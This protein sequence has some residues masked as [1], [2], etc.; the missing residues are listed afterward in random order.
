MMEL[1]ED[2]PLYNHPML[3]ALRNQQSRS[4][5][6]SYEN[7]KMFLTP[8]WSEVTHK[9]NVHKYMSEFSMEL[10]T[11]MTMCCCLSCEVCGG[12]RVQ[13]ATPAFF[14]SVVVKRLGMFK[15]VEEASAL[16]EL[17]STYADE[18][19]MYDP[20]YIMFR[21]GWDMVLLLAA[22]HREITQDVFVNMGIRK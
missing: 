4:E 10:A 9:N 11:H 6:V 12:E 8:S 21:C 1:P 13:F 17:W 3:V 18:D 22:L 15:C 7:E 2:H 19:L 14:R 16:A 20:R 5:A